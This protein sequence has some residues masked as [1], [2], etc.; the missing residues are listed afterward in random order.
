MGQSGVDSVRVTFNFKVFDVKETLF[1][2]CVTPKPELE[3]DSGSQV[4]SEIAF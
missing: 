3:S 2:V 4:G 1:P